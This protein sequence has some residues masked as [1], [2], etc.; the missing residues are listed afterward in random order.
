[1]EL[2]RSFNLRRY[3]SDEDEAVEEYTGPTAWTRLRESTDRRLRES[4]D[5]RL[6][7]SANQLGNYEREVADQC[8]D[9][10]PLQQLNDAYSEFDLAQEA[11]SLLQGWGQKVHLEGSSNSSRV[12]ASR[13]EH[14]EL[15]TPYADSL[16]A[17]VPFEDRF[18]SA[19]EA[20]R[21]GSQIPRDVAGLGAE[22]PR[23]RKCHKLQAPPLLQREQQQQPQ[24]SSLQEVQL[25]IHRA[26]NAAA[27]QVRPGRWGPKV[28]QL[29]AQDAR[30]AA[31]ATKR[32]ARR[33]GLP[34]HQEQAQEDARKNQHAEIPPRTPPHRNKDP[35]SKESHTSRYSP[36]ALQSPSPPHANRHHSQ[37]RLHMQMHQQQSARLE[38]KKAGRKIGFTGASGADRSRSR[39]GGRAETL[40]AKLP[41]STAPV[42]PIRQLKFAGTDV[43]RPSDEQARPGRNQEESKQC[44]DDQESAAARAAAKAAADIDAL[45]KAIANATADLERRQSAAAAKEVARRQ[46]EHRVAA[47][48]VELAALAAAA[49]AA[50]E[51]LAAEEAA[52]AHLRKRQRK[53]E[54][55]ADR[56][57][58]RWVLNKLTKRVHLAR[59][60][61]ARAERWWQWQRLRHV[62]RQLMRWTID[63]QAERAAALF[64][65]HRRAEQERFAEAAQHCSRQR[66]T[67]AWERWCCAVHIWKQ[68]A[69]VAAEHV[70]RL[71]SFERLLAR[72]EEG[73]P[74]TRRQQQSD[75]RAAVAPSQQQQSQKDRPPQEQKLEWHEQQ[76][77]D[78]FAVV[79]SRSRNTKQ[80]LLLTS[81]VHSQADLS[82][83]EY[84]SDP[85]KRDDFN[86]SK[87]VDDKGFE[88]ELSIV[89]SLESLV[90]SAARHQ[91]LDSRA[92]R[93]ETALETLPP[94]MELRARERLRRREMLQQ[95]YD[96]R[97]AEKAREKELE[98]AAQRET[99]VVARRKAREQKRRQ[100]S[101]VVAAAAAREANRRRRQ[102]A[103]ATADAHSVRLRLARSLRP[104]LQLV[105]QRRNLMAV[106]AEISDRSTRR[107]L[108]HEWRYQARAA[109]WLA[110]ARITGQAAA[111]RR[112]QTG[113]L[114]KAV[115]KRWAQA[116]AASAASNLE[117]ARSWHAVR[118]VE[119]ALLGW[120]DVACPRA[121]KRRVEQRD[122]KLRFM[123]H[124]WQKWLA[125]KQKADAV[126]AVK[127]ELWAQVQKWLH[128]DN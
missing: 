35:L 90:L 121:A 73:D 5:R 125:A 78:E 95:L 20:V 115:L 100:R 1:M 81:T 110:A 25:D 79:Q 52:T 45:D 62:W 107:R 36:P 38:K 128:E 29:A 114:V 83:H 49:N 69:E 16:A 117:A 14:Q 37:A 109:R 67:W 27:E 2:C 102:Q 39:N 65:V 6:R 97:E 17:L 12:R 93:A 47:K 21:D 98:A 89:D 72:Q 54:A 71:L 82:R 127:N 31:V 111:L 46:E 33:S 116:S 4:T 32:K 22:Q 124:R 61:V 63:K 56:R 77:A 108:I 41:N 60:Q 94:A 53:L 19:G 91:H 24:G 86:P 11:K 74:S 44:I 10:D 66:L 50:D 123:F 113:M 9:E 18:R 48:T 23:S 84:Q 118:R 112:L 43:V 75:P 55:A 126:G 26:V 85:R 76:I 106:S 80:P 101:A 58:Q 88:N 119:M 92:R 28:D 59:Q 15:P 13:S 99:V 103:A 70:Q 87:R 122:R 51:K 120:A 30:H 68:E 57:R 3:D 40:R 96:D 104:W 34:W 105:T 7:A 42:S 64:E 8:D